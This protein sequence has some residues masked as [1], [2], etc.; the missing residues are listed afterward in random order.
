MTTGGVA[1]RRDAAPMRYAITVVLLTAVVFVACLCW[2]VASPP[3]TGPD[4][5]AH[6][7]SVTRVMSGGG[8][9]L[10]YEA[11]M[12]SWTVTALTE[13]G[14]GYRGQRLDESVAVEDRST[15]FTPGEWTDLGADQMVQHPPLYYMVT[16]TVV[17]AVGGGSLTWDT[18][19]LWMRAT[20]GL[21]IAAAVPFIVGTSRRVSGSRRAGVVGG[22]ALLLVPFF[23]NSGGFVNNDP[24]L[25]LFCSA[26]LYFGVRA[27]PGGPLSLLW[28]TLSGIGLGLALL[29]K[30]LALLLIPV[31]A[32]LGVMAAIRSR[33]WRR[34]VLL[35]G[36][37]LSIAFA[38]GGWWW[39]RNLLVLGT[40][41]PSTLGDRERSETAHAAYDLGTFLSTS[42]LRFN[43]TFWG[44]GG[45]EELAFPEA[46][47][48]MAG[49][50]LL[51]AILVTLAVCSQRGTVALLWLFPVLIVATTF[52]NAHGIF[53]DTG[54]PDRG[55]QG[56]YIF[57]G[58]PAF[59]VT[60]ACL[61]GWSVRH[62]TPSVRRWMTGFFVIAAAA[63]TAT[64]FVWVFDRT[65]D[66]GDV[67]AAIAAAATASGVPTALPVALAACWAALVCVLA[68]VVTIPDAGGRP[69][70]AESLGSSA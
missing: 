46:V 16:A 69:P 55:I 19:Q 45:R 47:V 27:G 58:I 24:M 18:A 66:V 20:S 5:R 64:G 34:G 40:L 25:I 33:S 50:L 42:V 41:Q 68:A 67:G 52:S 12:E 60:A 61:A 7:N 62:A 37:P 51:V 22:A 4:E 1:A 31:V 39:L 59:A 11:Q 10:P 14:F 23:T 8:W 28:M 48:D 44:R 43:R 13:A 26:S 6:Y 57:A 29:S 32:A 21:L 2:A 49:I 38:V 36:A 54:D 15:V 63:A 56:R 17:T 53:W 30:G 3:F 65:W 35:V 9:P 70:A